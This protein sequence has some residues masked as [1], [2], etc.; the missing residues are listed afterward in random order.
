[1]VV[2]SAPAP[3]WCW[4]RFRWRPALALLG[5]FL[6]MALWQGSVV[7][8]SM[9][10]SGGSHQP[11]FWPFIWEGTG[12]LSGYLLLPIPYVALV[13]APSMA[14]GRRRFLAIHAAAF[15]LLSALLPP[16][17]LAMR[18]GIFRLAGWGT[19]DYG[20]LAYQLPMEWLKLAFWYVIGMGLALFWRHR[21]EARVREARE[22]GLRVQ[23]QEARLAA[24]AA[25]VDPHFLFNALNTIS[26]V[27]YEDLSRADGLLASLARMLRDGLEAGGP[28]W[29]L[30]REQEHLT[31]YLDFALARFGDRLSV[32]VDLADAPLEAVVPRFCLQRLVENSLKHQDPTR[33]L[34]IAIRGARTSEGL[35]LE[36][37]DNGPGPV[38]P[39]AALNGNG[40]GLRNLRETLALQF[41][42]AATLAMDHGAS[43]GCRVRLRLPL[44]AS[45]G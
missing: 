3:A 40:V 37:V 9:R 2:S 6:G 36:V 21:Q 35:T 4:P 31:A 38:D 17:F 34:H 15:V 45:H 42:D 28:L 14:Q 33:A 7:L 5:L 11:W 41:G 43:Q 44:E 22:A 19:Y 26:S 20:V 30:R 24:L 8:L 25:Q 10:G 1:M 16:L 13:N 32:R 39:A 12:Y 29:P 18:H 23:L 27:M